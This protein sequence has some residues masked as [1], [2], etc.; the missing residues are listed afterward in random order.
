[1]RFA[2][3]IFF[4]VTV[5]AAAV[6]LHGE[7]KQTNI[8]KF[9]GVA[10]ACRISGYAHEIECGTLEL[11][12]ENKDFSPAIDGLRWYRIPA[13]TR[14]GLPDPVIWISG[15]GND[16]VERAPVMAATLKRLLNSRDLIWMEPRGTPPA[17]DLACIPAGIKTLQT[18]LEPLADAAVVK[19][20]RDAMRSWAGTAVPPA[21]QH[22]MD[23]ERLRIALGISRV[24]VLAEDNGAEV[25]MEWAVIAPAAI[26]TVALDSPVLTDVST[27]E[28]R[29]LRMAS[30]LRQALASCRQSEACRSAYPDPLA[31]LQHVRAGLPR[32]V[33]IPHPQTGESESVRVTDEILAGMVARILRHPPRAGMLPAVLQA[34]ADGD[35]RPL[36]GLLA[37]TW[38]G[39]DQTFHW[40]PWLAATCSND[41]P[42]GG[43][44]ED[45]VAAW[46]QT[47]E[48]QQ[49]QRLCDGQL[50]PPEP[51]DSPPAGQYPLLVLQ[52]GADPVA[53]EAPS[54]ALVVE[55]PG[56]GHGML[57]YG[58]AADIVYR[59]VQF[60][61]M[62]AGSELGA[63]CLEQVPYPVPF[64]ERKRSQ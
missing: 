62:P 50:A 64:V 20:C 44:P 31:D 28:Q 29:A 37:A 18:L 7:D 48:R 21:R 1:M 53:S 15:F 35:W 32:T 5:L 8:T 49:Y 25:A 59:F 23:L 26:R 30:A 61:A 47:S 51:K 57:A 13:R 34:T 63:A 9:T 19:R 55:A 4:A 56:G 3:W 17:A 54:N 12:N 38:S 14:Y 11:A 24:N 52:G 43:S 46:F 41:Q 42:R 22:A 39:P 6:W 10:S 33:T 27:P 58:C 60:A 36:F 2:G 45:E 16:T 40:E